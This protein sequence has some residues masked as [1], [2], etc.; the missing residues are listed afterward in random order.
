ME[1]R[2]LNRAGL[3][4]AICALIGRKPKPKAEAEGARGGGLCALAG[5]GH[6]PMIWSSFKCTRTAVSLTCVPEMSKVRR[7]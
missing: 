5:G 4:F 6:G 3:V 1:R 7:A 2:A